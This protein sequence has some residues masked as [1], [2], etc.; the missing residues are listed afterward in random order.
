MTDANTTFLPAQGGRFSNNLVYYDRSAL[1]TT[2]NVG[3]NTDAPSFTFESNL[4]FA[5]DAPTQSAPTDL[6]APESGAIVGA[7]PGL[8]DPDSEN[9]G[10]DASSPAAGAGVN[11]AELTTNLSGAC[12]ASP[13]SIGANE[14]D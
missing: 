13:P 11:L 10:V 7:D 9:I 1:S 2:V 4:W 8:S 6:P 14:V 3:P 5:H 12:Y